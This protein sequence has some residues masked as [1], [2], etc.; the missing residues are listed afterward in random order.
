MSSDAASATTA[1]TASSVAT[2]DAAGRSRVAVATAPAA[3]TGASPSVS[4]ALCSVERLVEL[5]ARGG[6]Q[7]ALGASEV[8]KFDEAVEMA[9]V[10][11]EAASPHDRY[12]LIETPNENFLL[13]TNVIPKDTVAPR[14]EPI[15]TGLTA[16]T[17]MTS[18]AVCGRHAVSRNAVQLARN[19]VGRHV[20][21]RGDVARNDV[22]GER[23]STA[24]GD[25]LGRLYEGALSPSVSPGRDYVLRNAR[26]TLGYRGQLVYGSYLMYHKEHLELAL[27]LNKASYVESVLRDVYAPGLLEHHNVCDAE[28]LLWMLYSG[29]RS[30]CS[31]D[32]C[33][34]REQAGYHMPFPALLPALFYEPVLDYVTYMNLAELYVYVWYRGYEFTSTADELRLSLNSVTLDRLQ[35]VL[36][37]V[38]ARF[39]G[40]EVPCW[41]ASS[42]TCVFCALYSQNRLCLDVARNGVG[43]V[44]YSPILLQDCPAAVTDVTLSH[45]LPGQGTVTLFPVYHIGKLLD[46]VRYSENGVARLELS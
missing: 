31:R 7:A 30:F 10:A 5:S 16:A 2:M 42:R 40:R 43:A 1:T 38:Q 22:D 25:L 36:K 8:L 39:S 29:P 11:C 44:F 12:R 35:E 37:A 4:T 26:Q 13:V 34:G 9:L 45:V 28:G 32:A 33:F 3:T 18:S 14:S 27:S 6:E 24:N 21:S 20:M 46:A 17:R 19:G 41:P 23:G 15:A